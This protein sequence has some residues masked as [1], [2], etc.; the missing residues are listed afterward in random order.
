MSNPQTTLFADFQEGMNAK[1]SEAF[2]VGIDPAY[3]EDKSATV[4]MRRMRDGEMRL[5]DLHHGIAD[6][7]KNMLFQIKRTMLPKARHRSQRLIKKLVNKM[8]PNMEFSYG[9]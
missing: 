9:Q 8:F 7:Q 3:G 5:I 4:V 2:F 1:I 6:S